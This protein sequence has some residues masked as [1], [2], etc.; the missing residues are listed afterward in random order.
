MRSIID[1][2]SSAE[3]QAEQIRQEAAASARERTLSAAAEAE[4]RLSE[5]EHCERDNLRTATFEAEQR[6]EMLANKTLA[7]MAALADADCLK[8][9]EKLPETIDYLMKKVLNF[10]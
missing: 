9:G 2:I 6:G 7:E 3:A 8:A 10:A 4:K 5:L 1:E